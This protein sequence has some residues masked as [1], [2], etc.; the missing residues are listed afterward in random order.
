MKTKKEKI[1]ITGMS[2]SGKSTLLSRLMMQPSLKEMRF[3]EEQ[4][5]IYLER[6]PRAS[7]AVKQTLMHTY[8]LMNENSKGYFISDRGIHDYLIFSRELTKSEMTFPQEELQ[9]RYDKVFVLPDIGNKKE[10]IQARGFQRLINNFYKKTGHELLLVPER[11]NEENQLEF[12]M[13]EIGSIK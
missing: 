12:V 10:N 5:R 2:G 13:D 6:Y 1:V 4:A 3:I 8:Q 7:N 9:Q 11:I